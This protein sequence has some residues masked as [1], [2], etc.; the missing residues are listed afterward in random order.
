MEYG[1]LF[2]IALTLSTAGYSQEKE[3]TLEGLREH[4]D[5]RSKLSNMT[6][7]NYSDV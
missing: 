2:I 3:R 5:M 1:T 4:M 6:L 7:D